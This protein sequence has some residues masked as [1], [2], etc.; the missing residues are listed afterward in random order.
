[1]GILFSM[2]RIKRLYVTFSG[3]AFVGPS[4]SVFYFLEAE[5][6]LQAAVVDLY[7]SF[8]S[9]MPVGSSATV[10]GSGDILDSETGELV[11][12]WSEGGDLGVGFS[13]EADFAAGVGGRIVW[14]TEGF[15]AGRR[16]RGSTFLVPLIRS[17]YHSDGTL[18]SGAV[19]GIQDGV[20][21]FAA[22]VEGNHV[23]WTRPKN[24]AGGGVSTVIS[25]T[26]ADK[27]SWLRSRRT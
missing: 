9:W 25:S 8:Q 11:G 2:A 13:G 12:A 4:T 26:M 15:A 20:D 18:T 27:V 21:T 5:T 14:G 24:G 22:A 6:G 16:V 7:E 10:L 23:I 3:P 17:V 19:Q 1:M